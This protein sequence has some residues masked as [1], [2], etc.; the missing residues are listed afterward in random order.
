MPLAIPLIELLLLLVGIGMAGLSRPQAGGIVNWLGKVLG[1]V[2]IVGG[3][4]SIDQIVKLDR[5]VTHEI[6]KATQAITGRGVK[7]FA[8]LAHY[9][10]VVGYWS[11]YWP[12]GLFHAVQ[13]LV[14][15]VIPRQVDARTK[16]IAKDA[17]D[18]KAA[19]KASAA[20]T[21]TV[22]KR[23][24]AVDRTKE[25]TRIERVAMPHAAEWDWLHRH[26]DAVRKSVAAVATAG[27][28]VA[29]PHAPAFPIPFGYTIKSLR[30]RL[31]RVEALLGV[32][33]FAAVLASTLGVSLRC[34]KP[35]GNLGRLAR[36]VCRAPTWLIRFLVAGVVE[37]FI[38]SDLCAFTSLMTAEA[39]KIRP[40]L[41]TLVDVEDALINCGG[42]SK[43]MT[44]SLP[45][46]SLPAVVGTSPLAA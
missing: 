6:G 19:A 7:W 33:A 14:G 26:F 2:P 38:V 25:V 37:A 3:I 17:A 4:L 36:S 34:V 31:H 1:N 9:Q 44:F 40:A 43:P 10:D 46:I 41:L 23:I 15:H 35:G 5:W 45:P 28:T 20:T 42:T 39:V 27:A 16:P 11:L 13:H 18:A 29:L 21:A 30:R 32:G 22:P 12:V 8:Q 24:H